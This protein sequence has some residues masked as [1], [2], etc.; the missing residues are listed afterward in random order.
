ML[1]TDLLSPSTWFGA[2]A[3]TIPTADLYFLNACQS[4]LQKWPVQSGPI[5][6]EGANSFSCG[7]AIV[8][9]RRDSDAVVNRLLQSDFER[10]YYIID[11]DLWAAEHDATLPDGYRQRLLRLR[12]G[13][14]NQLA[15]KAD[16]II[17]SSEVLAD[18]YEQKGYKV[19][20]LDP[21]WSEPMADLGHFDALD[22]SAPIELGYLG[23]ASHARDREFVL[24][25][26]ENL[27]EEKAN[28]RL[29]IVGRANVP[30]RLLGQSRLK[31]LR[32]RPWTKHRKRL[33]R[34]RFHYS[35]YP[36][37]PTDF[38][39]A[40]SLNKFAEHAVSGGIGVYSRSWQYADFISESKG[41]IL[42]ENTIDA[43]TGWLLECAKS[44]KHSLE[45]LE[46]GAAKAFNA[47]SL[48]KQLEF[49]KPTLGL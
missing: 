1:S 33:T 47:K 26:F 37:E 24:K 39:K 5:R 16:R 28:V 22:R 23:S 34:L 9:C 10:L 8:I 7:T 19:T 44:G 31:I 11:D 36:T 17:V 35:L 2:A 13:Q 15:A 4:W 41:G 21:Y 30:D 18:R 42:L 32:P 48:E 27:L 46:P 25:V 20:L 49:W 40:R 43:W 6:R 45:N 38:N 3:Q 14:H 29:T 12:E